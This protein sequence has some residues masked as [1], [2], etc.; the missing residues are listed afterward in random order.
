MKNISPFIRSLLCSVILFILCPLV[1]FAQQD[2]TYYY[3]AERETDKYKKIEYYTKAIELCS[4]NSG[5][6]KTSYYNRAA[7]K[8]ELEDVYGAISDLNNALSVEV[9]TSKIYWDADIKF[10]T[11]VENAFIYLMLGD[12]YIAQ[13]KKEK[14]CLS[15]SKSGE[16]GEKLAYERIKKYCR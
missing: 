14:A 15:Y 5:E 2:T 9:L 8:M 12:C 7:L 1:S 6:L 4:P 16:L 13:M 10:F 11:Q 3:Q